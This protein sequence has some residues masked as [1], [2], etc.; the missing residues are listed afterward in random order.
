[1]RHE[2]AALGRGMSEGMLSAVPFSQAQLGTQRESIKDADQHLDSVLEAAKADRKKAA[3]TLAIIGGL[4]CWMVGDLIGGLIGAAIGYGIVAVQ[5][6][7]TN[8]LNDD[9]PRGSELAAARATSAY[10]EEVRVLKDMER[11]VAA[12]H[13]ANPS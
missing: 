4:I 13:R 6:D 8:P 5:T 7:L 12:Y 9:K 10:E 3:I 11:R 2:G 1:M